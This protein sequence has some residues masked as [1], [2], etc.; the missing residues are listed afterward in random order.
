MIHLLVD[1]NLNAHIQNGLL[2]MVPAA[3][4][5]HVRDVG[6][7]T[8]SD[9]EILAWAAA[10]GRVVL[11]HDRQTLPGFAYDRVA[12][13]K[14]MPGVFV[15]SLTLPTGAA[16]DEIALAICCLTE[17]KCCNLVRFIPM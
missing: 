12:A 3:D 13:G 16:I 1:Q 2:Q 15:V 10:E 7:E 14:P 5:V 6:L 11:T 8:A 4:V 17:G 9:P